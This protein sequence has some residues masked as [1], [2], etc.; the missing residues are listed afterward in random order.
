MKLINCI[1]PFAVPRQCYNFYY[2]GRHQMFTAQMGIL[3]LNGGC[4]HR[5]SIFKAINSCCS[6]NVNKTFLKLTLEFLDKKIA[7]AIRTWTV[8]LF[9]DFNAISD[10]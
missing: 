9:T 6:H 3:T 2:L 5:N 10:G 8:A 7:L 4:S 1:G